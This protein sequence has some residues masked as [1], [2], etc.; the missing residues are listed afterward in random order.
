MPMRLEVS[1]SSH[2]YVDLEIEEVGDEVVGPSAVRRWLGAV[3]GDAVPLDGPV[4]T[5]RA[6]L[7]ERTFH[8]DGRDHEFF[9]GMQGTGEVKVRRESILVTLVPGLRNFVERFS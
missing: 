9:P 2:A 5:V 1:G 7:P 4:V 6:R 8:S 3:V